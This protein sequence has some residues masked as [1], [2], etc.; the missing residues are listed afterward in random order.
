VSLVNFLIAAIMG[1]ILRYAF[2]VELP[3][4]KFRF[5]LHG[6]SHV[7]MLGWL[8]LALFALIAHVFL[9][10][11][12]R[13]SRYLKRL[14]WLTE[15][16]VVG[17]AIAF[18]IQGYGPVSIAFSSLHVVFSY[19]FANY[20]F[21]KIP[22][23]SQPA[24]SFLKAS[25]WFMILSTVALW[26]IPP[27][28]VLGSHGSAL[29]YAAIQFFLHFQFNGWFLFAGLALFFRLADQRSVTFPAV[30]LRWFF[31]LL[32]LGTFL[33]YALAVA[34]SNPIPL[35][36]GLN[37]I[38]VVVQLLAA[39]LFV[40]LIWPHHR[41]FR[42]RFW[43]TTLL[44]LAFVSF[45]AKLTIQSAVVLPVVA[46][47]AYTIRN[48]V[49]GFIHLILLGAMTFFLLAFSIDHQILRSNSRIIQAG[50][51]SL[52]AGFVLTE[53]VLFLQGTFFWGAMGFLP[54]YYE[55]LFA[56]SC[57][58]PLGVFFLVAGTFNRSE[59]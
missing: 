58:L 34:W 32:V 47:A 21:R 29:Y 1:L 23:V 30:T 35:V 39:L 52:I 51:V 9:S 53:G 22:R 16:S 44:Y 26:A 2:V 5:L 50:L 37:S 17:M 4:V 18:P 31:R 12:A 8:Y 42:G 7:A 33:T 19:V 27:I 40:Q 45:L 25:L 11:E 15:A 20:V 28:I 14:F 36:F 24:F 41:L 13:E 46:T 10:K 55:G 54:F 56:A 43:T 3:W 38:G 48:Y 59:V 49:I 6:H 57:L